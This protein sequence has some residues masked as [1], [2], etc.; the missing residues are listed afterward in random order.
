[1]LLAGIAVFLVGSTLC[2]FAW[3][4]VLADP[5]P[6]DPGASGPEPSSP[7]ASRVVGD[8][9]SAHE[10][11]KIQGY[12]ASVWGISSVL[13]PLAGGLII[14][15]ASWAWIFWINVPIGLVAA[16]GFVLFLHEDVTRQA[17]SIDAIGAAL[18]TVAIASLMMALDRRPE[19]PNRQRSGR[20][21]VFIVATV[22][23]VVQERPR[24]GSDARFRALGAKRPIATANAATLLSGM[25]IIG[26]TT[27]LPMYVQGVMRQSPLVAG[28]RP[29]HDGV[30]L[31][32]RRHSGG[33]QLRPLRASPDAA[34][35]SRADPDRVGGVRA[36]RAPRPRPS[37]QASDRS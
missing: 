10:R 5:V 30:R 37:W 23:F 1:M 9:Y 2:G 29:D 36:A 11:G 16:I 34:L 32:D 19:H 3:S 6:A 31:A 24:R 4:D 17:R 14:Q 35:R 28:S 26:L 13:G 21:V 33:S 12:L 27:F 15:H 25:A 22:M 8:L 18:F 7:S 20:A